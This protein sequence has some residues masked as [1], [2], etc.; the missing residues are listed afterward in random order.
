MVPGTSRFP[1]PAR[2]HLTTMRLWTIHP[3]YLAGVGLVALWREAPLARAVIVPGV[4]R[5]WERVGAG[6]AT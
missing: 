5:A 1:H 6:A 3:K 4:V 2:Q